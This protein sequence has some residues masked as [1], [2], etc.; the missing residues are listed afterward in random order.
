MPTSQPSCPRC[1]DNL[2]VR[3]EQIISGRRVMEAYYCGR[4]NMDWSIENMHAP[5]RRREAERRKRRLDN[6]LNVEPD[7]VGEFDVVAPPQGHDSWPRLGSEC[8]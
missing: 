4:C 6:V 2:F 3:A 5:E 1:H 7:V 8:R